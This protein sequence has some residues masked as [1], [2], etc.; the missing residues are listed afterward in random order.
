[1]EKR[2]SLLHISADKELRYNRRIDALFDSRNT[3]CAARD[4][5][6]NED[7]HNI[8]SLEH[9]YALSSIAA[10]VIPRDGSR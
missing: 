7:P 9:P 8:G 4:V 5:R 3:E 6:I 2:S 10:T 1:M